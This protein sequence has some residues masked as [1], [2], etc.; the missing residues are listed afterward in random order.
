MQSERKVGYNALR[1][2]LGRAN[3]SLDYTD[4]FTGA[5]LEETGE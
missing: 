4:S 2:S 1:L 3:E 5:E